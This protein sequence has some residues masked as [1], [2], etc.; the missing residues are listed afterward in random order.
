MANSE[1]QVAVEIEP[2]IRPRS[3]VQFIDRLLSFLSSVKLGITIMI[4]LIFFTMVGTFI[5]QHNIEGFDKYYAALT[6]A[7]RELYTMLGL[8]DLYH[9]WWFETLLILFSLNLVL[10]SIDLFPKAWK[11]VVEPKLQAT[12]SFLETQP[13]YRRFRA[14]SRVELV[15][16]LTQLMTASKWRVKVGGGALFAEKGVWN[17]FVVFI[18][19]IGV[20]IIL[21]AGFVGSRWG[22]EGMMAMAPGEEAT[23]IRINGSPVLGIPDTNRPLPF[24]VKCDNLRVD[25]RDPDGPLAQGNFDNWYTDVT[26]DQSGQKQSTSVFMNHPADYE[27]FR[28]FQASFGP[29]GGASQVTLGVRLPDGR[30]QTVSIERDKAVTVAGLG[31]VSF[32]NFLSDFGMVEGQ[33]QSVA[34]EYSRPAAQLEVVR[35][36]GEHRQT[37]A[38]SSDMMKFIESQSGMAERLQ[39]AGFQFTLKDFQRTPQFHVLQVQYDP[40]VDYTYFGYALLCVSLA[41]V[42][43]FSHQRVWA[44][45]EPGENGGALI[46]LGAHTNRNKPA[47]EKKFNELVE[48]VAAFSVD[49]TPPGRTLVEEGSVVTSR[50]EE[51]RTQAHSP[52][53]TSS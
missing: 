18:V 41:V 51:E 3:S 17:R 30:E 19:H 22:Y 12:P 50:V 39:V 16:R 35:A 52:D 25:L 13:F 9:T 15:D 34:E 49:E 11:F 45:V 44:V 1:V 10:V 5:M 47:L 48:Q 4:V 46:H 21:G 28:F 23:S 43:M 27:G 40:G 31:Q 6:P 37:W 32:V 53:E 7:E 38:F 8:F 33:P 2:A 26:F 14:D 24:K 36:N 20:L 29:P 42:F